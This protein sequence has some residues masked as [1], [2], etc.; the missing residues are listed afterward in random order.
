M[1]DL[2][3]AEPAVL[4]ARRGVQNIKKQHLTEI[5]SMANP[6][7]AVKMTMESVCILIGYKVSSWR[8][9][10]LAIRKDDFIP[11]IVNYNNEEQLTGE[12]RSYMEKT[13]LSRPDFTFETVNRAS[14]ACGPLVQWVRAQLTYSSILNKVGPLKEE[15]DLLEAGARKT[16][17]QLYALEEMV[18]ELEARI[19]KYK[20]DYSSLIRETENIKMEMESVEKRWLKVLSLWRAF[21]PKKKDGRTQLYSSKTKQ[22]RSLAH[23]LLYLPLLFIQGNMIIKIERV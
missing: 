8:D 19:D 10:Q 1:K 9:V 11:S 3:E 2:E 23:H 21:N 7:A 20:N 5:R 16:R 13:Y 22:K 15:V 14:K 4:E 18:K 12:L 17:A 6:P